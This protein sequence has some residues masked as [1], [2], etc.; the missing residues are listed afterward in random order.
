MELR[1]ASPIMF[2]SIVDGPGLRMVIWTQGCIHNCYGCHNTQTHSLNG[3]YEIQC[4]EVI[5]G[6]RKSKLQKGITISGGEPFLQPKPLELIA[7]EAKRIKMD[8]WAYTG[9]KFEELLDKNNIDYYNRINLLKQIDILV[10]GKFEISKKDIGLM[11]R[12]SSNQRIID[13]QRSLKSN[14]VILSYEY[15]EE[16]LSMVK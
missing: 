15:M 1:V 10:D 12:G 11:Y 5:D 4:G 8:V 2:D 13:V 3:G 14:E 9:F 6:L 16:M 7:K